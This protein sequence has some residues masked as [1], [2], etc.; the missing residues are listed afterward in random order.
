MAFIPWPNGVQLCFDFTTGAQNWQF[1]L[2][3]RKSSGA[4]TPTDLSDLSA[5]GEAWFTSHLDALMGTDVTLRQVRATD[6]TSQ[7]APQD[8]ETSGLAGTAG[9]TSMTNNV[10]RVVSH[11]TAKRGRSYR[12]RS[13]LS[14]VPKGLDTSA[15]SFT[16]GHATDLVNAFTSLQSTLDTIG[17]D[18]VVA[19]TQHNGAVTNPAE[20][21]EV[22]AFVVDTNFDSQRNRLAGRGT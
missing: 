2:A 14:G 6:M 19:S 16:T 1:C 10:A 3:L 8:I 9:N 15:T 20:L 21:N 18:I 22:I 17:F 11:R 7:G 12:G 13:Y 5:T 4:P